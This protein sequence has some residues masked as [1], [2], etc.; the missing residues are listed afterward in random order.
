MRL[1]NKD[2]MV[3]EQQRIVFQFLRKYYASTGAFRIVRKSMVEFLPQL[4]E[5]HIGTS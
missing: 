5:V 4:V 2:L 1:Q 3:L